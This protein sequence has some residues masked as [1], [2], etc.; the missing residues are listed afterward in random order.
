MNNPF[1]A[2]AE[3]SVKEIRKK[4]K[5]RFAVV[6]GIAE[7]GRLHLLL[8]NATS[9]STKAYAKIASYQSPSIGDRVLVDWIGNPANPDDGTYIVIGKVI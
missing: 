5:P 7:S 6:T 1:Q 4:T 2:A 9:A 3:A 8:G